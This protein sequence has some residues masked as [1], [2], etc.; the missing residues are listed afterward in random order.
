MAQKKQARKII[1][2]MFKP[3]EPVTQYFF[4][5]LANVS[6]AA[7]SKAVDK[8]RIIINADGLVPCDNLKN[9]L[10]LIKHITTSLN[11]GTDEERR[12]RQ[13]VLRILTTH[14]NV[15]IDVPE[16]I[17]YSYDKLPHEQT[18]HIGI[19]EDSEFIPIVS[20][21]KFELKHDEITI[22][23]LNC[24]ITIGLEKGKLAH[25]YVGEHTAG[26]LFYIPAN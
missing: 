13:A 19:V 22:R 12:Y 24:E 7:I 20:L 15:D 14:S 26:E 11:A 9:S 6:Q 23:P 25:L 3:G 2:K 10:F 4:S 8:H 21:T 16:P 18:F 1:P 17:Q 5:Q